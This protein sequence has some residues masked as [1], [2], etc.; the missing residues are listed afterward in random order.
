[1]AD[2]NIEWTD[3]VWN[4]I[5]GCT[6]VSEGCRHCYAERM[7]KRLKAMGLTQYQDVSIAGKWSGNVHLVPDLLDAPLHWKKPRRVFVNSM[8]DLFHPEVSNEFIF[9]IF[10][11][12]FL[13]PQHTFIILTKRPERMAEWF[14]N[15]SNGGFSTREIVKGMVNIFYG[16]HPADKVDGFEWPL[17]NVWLGVSVE[18]QKAADERIPLLLETPAAVRFVSCEPLL[19]DVDLKGWI[20]K[21]GLWVNG[22][23]KL[24]WVICGGESGPGA[25]PMHPDWARSLRDQCQDAGV[26][27]F[28]KQWG[29]W[30]PISEMSETETD[31]IYYPLSEKDVL[32]VRNCKVKNHPVGFDGGDHWFLTNGKPSYLTFRIGKKKAGRLLDG[33]EW[34]QYPDVVNG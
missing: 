22:D 8:S 12:M 24:D 5:V 11:R 30:K 1:M 34:N 26:P 10:S 21:N 28:F 29:E 25:R 15:Y 18:N 16:K 32:G 27:F 2:S 33:V 14:N 31:E 19:G 13:A 3:K 20:Y 17:P 7:A 4:P 6:K 9:N 23:K